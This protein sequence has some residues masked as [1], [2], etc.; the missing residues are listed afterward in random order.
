MIPAA[1]LHFLHLFHH[2]SRCS[3]IFPLMLLRFTG[4][5]A[6]KR[7]AEARHNHATAEHEL[8]K[9]GASVGPLNISASGV[10]VDNEDRTQGKKDQ[11]IGSGKEFVGNLFGNDSLTRE[12]KQQNASGEGQEAF[13]QV[14]NYVGGAADRVTGTIGAAAANLVG[15]KDAQ[16]MST[17]RYW[18]L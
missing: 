12:G 13:G 18:K 3:E 17:V 7:E 15:N 5:P 8:S 4:N 1:F 10:T 14:K 16:G 9:A 6:D 2:L 11:T